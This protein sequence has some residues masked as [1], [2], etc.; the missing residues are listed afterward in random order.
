MS[1]C[2]QKSKKTIMCVKKI[3][4]GKLSTHTFEEG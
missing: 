1:V 3:L 4:F 2:V